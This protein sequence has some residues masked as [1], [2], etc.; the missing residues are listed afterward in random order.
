MQIRILWITIS[1]AFAS[2]LSEPL[3]AQDSTNKVMPASIV[4]LN[5]GNS[6]MYLI[7][8]RFDMKYAGIGYEWFRNAKTS[9]NGYL[10][11]YYI[12]DGSYNNTQ[13]YNADWQ[14][15]NFGT[16]NILSLR[17]LYKWY[18]LHKVK[19]ARGLYLGGGVNCAIKNMYKE[20]DD[21]EIYHKVDFYAGL[22]WGLGYRI[23]IKKR[24]SLEIF[25]H[26]AN[27]GISLKRLLTQREYYP[28][29]ID[30][31]DF[32]IGYVIFKKSGK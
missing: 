28:I 2:G 21:Q 8:P 29:G 20:F 32:S 1:A 6:L 3:W 4:K 13:A 9:L 12:E 24:I 10:D 16:K 14:L 22:G 27:N 11:Y 15:D 30:L 17:T 7:Y 25:Y 19:F 31:L 23:E 18:P 5:I 26:K